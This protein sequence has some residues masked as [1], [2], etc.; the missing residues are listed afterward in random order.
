MATVFQ[1]QARSS[2]SV[3]AADGLMRRDRSIGGPL[4]DALLLWGQ[5]AIA[6][7]VTWALITGAGRLPTL[8]ADAVAGGFVAFVTILTY[9]HL[10]AVAPRAYLNRDVFGRFPRRF[11]LVPLLLVAGLALSQ[12]LLVI[13]IVLTVFWDVHHSAMQTFGLGRIYDL[14]AGNDPLALR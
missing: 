8:E 1:E 14:K 2:A 4:F 5:P 6:F 7:L 12:T 11:V 3:R 9:A 10:I 13:A